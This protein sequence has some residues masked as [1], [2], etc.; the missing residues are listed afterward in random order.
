MQPFVTLEAHVQCGGPE[1][2]FDQQG[3]R[4]A[5]IILLGGYVMIQLISGRENQVSGRVLA[6]RAKS[7]MERISRVSSSL[8][9]TM[10]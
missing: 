3:D 6:M 4:F 10:P 1:Q 9:G 7:M 5:A 2:P 8:T